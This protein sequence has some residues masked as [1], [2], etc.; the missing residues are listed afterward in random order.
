MNASSGRIEVEDVQQ[1]SKRAAIAFATAALDKVVPVAQRHERVKVLLDRMLEEF[2]QW[3]HA[4]VASE[5]VAPESLPSARLYDSYME[6]LLV[7]ADEYSDNSQMLDLIGA[8]IA[9]LSFVVW[10]M[11][12]IERTRTPD[13]PFVLP[14]DIAEVDWDVL[15]AGLETA[16]CAA[17]DSSDMHAWQTQVLRRLMS[18]H[19]VPRDPQES[20]QPVERSFF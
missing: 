9:I 18:E 10:M 16:A 4:G 20:G 5:P 11:D 3:Q 19:P 12:S 17:Q 6:P 2:W 13:K 7:F 1:L 8:C 15:M 14:A